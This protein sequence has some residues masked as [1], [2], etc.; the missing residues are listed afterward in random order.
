MEMTDARAALARGTIFTGFIAA[1]REL[2]GERGLRDVRD[3]LHD[4]TRKATLDEIVL[5]TSWLPVVHVI[6]W[7]EAIYEGL[8]AKDDAAFLRFVDRGLEQGFGRV[9]KFFLGFAS[10]R[11][12]IERAPSLWRKQH[13]HGK[14]T[15]TTSGDFDYALPEAQGSSLADKGESFVATVTL[16]DH[17]FIDVPLSRRALAEAWRHVLTLARVEEVKESH[18]VET[19]GHAGERALVARLTWVRS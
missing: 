10:P 6:R 19:T 2:W 17:P 14:L 5:A 7:H 18:S 4:D 15:V 13:T 1:T 11:L 3:R 16:R 8:A 12:L 9:Q